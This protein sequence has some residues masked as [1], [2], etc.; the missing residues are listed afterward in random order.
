MYNNLDSLSFRPFGSVCDSLTEERKSS[1][2]CNSELTRGN[3]PKL[4]F[5]RCSCDAYVEVLSGKGILL[6]SANPNSAPIVEFVINH[7]FSIKAGVCFSIVSASPELQMEIYIPKRYSVKPVKLNRDYQCRLLYPHIQIT[8][9]MGCCY[10]SHP[11]EKHKVDIS[12]SVYELIFVDTGTL[13]TKID[14]TDY[15]VHEKEIIL[16]GPGQKHKH[17]V[18]DNKELSYTSVQFQMHVFSG[19]Q[20]VDLDQRLLNKV[21]PH[22]SKIHDRIKIFT[23]DA[24]RD[25]PYNENLMMCMLTEIIIRLLQEEYIETA[26]VKKSIA[27]Y[28]NRDELF[29]Q[30]I[31][32]IKAKVDYPITVDEICK[33]FSISRSYL[34][35]TFIRAINQTPK[36]Y[37]SDLR[38]EKSC[39]L[40]QKSNYTVTDVAKALHYSSVHAFSNMFKEKY[41][42][43]PGEY[44]KRLN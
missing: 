28:R 32:Y 6:V 41:H 20:G 33:K 38:L 11:S 4:Q 34:Q 29:S 44:A 24:D 22:N 14:E 15:D 39:Q 26:P 36:R 16:Y 43:S 13:H 23:E 8:E 42:I 18:L 5:Y 37:I 12:N 19:G 31:A 30:I 27:H 3:N 17:D 35:K 40:L 25:I 7:Q 21:F 2:K 1:M 10:N 9:I